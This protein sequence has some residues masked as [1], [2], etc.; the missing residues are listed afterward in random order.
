MKVHTTASGW[1][2]GFSSALYAYSSTGTILPGLAAEVKQ[3]LALAQGQDYRELAQL[4]VKVAPVP[5]IAEL[6]GR[7][8]WNRHATG[9]H[10]LPIRCRSNGKLKTWKTRPTD[11]R[12][13][14]K[15]GFK[16]CFYLTPANIDCWVIAP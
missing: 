3:C 9:S 8:F 6:E 2:T 11:F 13:P 5:T 10:G 4:Y 15:Y 12:L 7:Q 16:D 1:H 14:V